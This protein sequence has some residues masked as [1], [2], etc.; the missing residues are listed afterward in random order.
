MTETSRLQRA[1]ERNLD[2]LGR[3]ILE[4]QAM[5][6]M[7][8][9]GSTHG[10]DFFRIAYDAMFNDLLSHSIKVL[11]RNSQSTSFWYIYRCE[12][13][14]ID[15]YISEKRYRLEEY[16]QMADR[17]KKVRDKTHFHIDRDAVFSPADVWKDVN[18]KGSE[19]KQV[20]DD[21]WDILEYVYSQKFGKE[22]TVLPYDG[23]DA[24]EV[25]KTA[26][27]AGIIAK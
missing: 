27:D 15:R 6:G 4:R 5:L 18:I 24:T 26:Q 14:L 9:A 8:A 10:M 23:H 19:L 25:I 22:F 1:L 7:E 20:I 21:V 2:E 11:D 17:L 13:V 12:K 16:G 3:A